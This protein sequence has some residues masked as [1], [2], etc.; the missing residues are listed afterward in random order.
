MQYIP[1]EKNFI[2]MVFFAVKA[3]KIHVKLGFL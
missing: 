1:S 3:A 2:F